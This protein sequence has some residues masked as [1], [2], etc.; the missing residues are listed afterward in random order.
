ME[1]SLDLRASR[2]FNS[3]VMVSISALTMISTCIR[4]YRPGSDLSVFGK[5]DI[6]QNTNNEGARPSSPR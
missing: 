2:S 3:A 1:G 5:D 6:T 4:S